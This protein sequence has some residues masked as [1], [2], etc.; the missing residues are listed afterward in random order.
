MFYIVFDLGIPGVHTTQRN[1]SINSLIKGGNLFANALQEMRLY[2]AVAYIKDLIDRFL[3]SELD[4]LTKLLMNKKHY[5]DKVHA[6]LKASVELASTR[7]LGKS[8]W[9][10]EDVA[11]DVPG[12]NCAVRET[13]P[14]GGFRQHMVPVGPVVLGSGIPGGFLTVRAAATAVETSIGHV[15]GT[16]DETLAETTSHCNTFFFTVRR[17]GQPLS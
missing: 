7:C 10:V 9:Q 12:R 2:E 11:D 3:E 6:H 14:K 17:R 15:P 4:E 8:G 16:K 5:C 13:L 1:E